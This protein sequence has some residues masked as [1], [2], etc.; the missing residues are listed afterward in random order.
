MLA[1]ASK[2]PADQLIFDLEDS[3]TLERKA[4]ARGLI[5]ATL[6]DE[7]GPSGVRSVRINGVASA[8][9]LQDLSALVAGAGT[10]LDSIVLPKVS[11]A[12][13][14]AFVDHALSQL[15]LAHGVP[16]GRIG[17]EVQLEDAAGVLDIERIVEVTP[18]LEVITYGPGDL[19][20]A[21]G[22]PVFPI[23]GNHPHYPGD[24]W[25][26]VHATI[27]LHAR[28]AGIQPIAG[29]YVQV[30]DLDGLEQLALRYR[31]LGFDGMWVLHPGQIQVANSVFGVDQVAMERASDLLDAF[32]HATETA[33]RGA[34]LFGTEMIDE[35]SRRQAEALVARAQREGRR[36]RPVPAEVPFAERARW[37]EAAENDGRLAR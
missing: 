19:A 11:D 13:Q 37:R 2:L 32:A 27:V 24:H 23:G 15:E 25:H 28:R 36:P 17:I 20:G 35:A 9:T 12:G 34:A 18:R 6:V 14:L 31:G 29:P 16:L 7:A 1:K 10:R 33:G 3:V 4:E 5:V 30:G 21:L 8:L 22:L 26:H